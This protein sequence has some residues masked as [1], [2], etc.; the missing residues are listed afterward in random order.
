VRSSTHASLRP[1][2]LSKLLRLARVGCLRAAK[3]LMHDLPGGW[4]LG[5]VG[6]IGPL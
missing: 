5:I 6:E 3:C 2:A 4:R 1:T